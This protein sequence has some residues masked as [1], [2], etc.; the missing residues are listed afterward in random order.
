MRDNYH[1]SDRP[2]P[3]GDSSRD[4]A[5]TSLL[6][7]PFCGSKNLTITEP[8]HVACCNCGATGP[9]FCASGTAAEIAWNHRHQPNPTLHPPGCGAA[10]PR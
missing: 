7:C 1:C 5:S 4:V 10:E 8:C 2:V 9:D 3:T 6:G